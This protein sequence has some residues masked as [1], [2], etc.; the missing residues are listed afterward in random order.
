MIIT[1]IIKLLWKCTLALFGHVR[2]GSGVWFHAKCVFQRDALWWWCFALKWNSNDSSL[3]K[4]TPKAALRVPHDAFNLLW[5]PELV[6]CVVRSLDFDPSR[7]LEKL[8]RPLVAHEKP[9]ILFFY[10]F[11]HFSI[12]SSRKHGCAFLSNL[13]Q[14]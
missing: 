13:L 7:C 4:W 6:L 9:I 14:K 1:I 2:P 11:Y 10:P 5:S 3:W 8:F 12:I